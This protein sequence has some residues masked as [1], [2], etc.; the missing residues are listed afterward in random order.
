MCSNVGLFSR[1]GFN[2]GG[3]VGG[4]GPFVGVV[5]VAAV[6]ISMLMKTLTAQKEGAI[7]A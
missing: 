6:S 7:T 1:S 4:F 2:A 5:W 3:Y